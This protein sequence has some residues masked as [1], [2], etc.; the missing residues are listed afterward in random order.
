MPELP[1]LFYTFAFRCDTCDNDWTAPALLA[2]P[3]GA[4]QVTSVCLGCGEEIFPHWW[5]E[6]DSDED[7][8]FNV[9]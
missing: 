5:E 8:D 6:A 7:I 4:D 9:S 2:D 1:S 3:D